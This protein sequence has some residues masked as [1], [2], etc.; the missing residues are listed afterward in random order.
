LLGLTE[1]AVPA[2][3]AGPVAGPQPGKE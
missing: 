1:P 2:E 3:P